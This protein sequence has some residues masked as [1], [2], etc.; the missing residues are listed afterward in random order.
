MIAAGR[1]R[2]GSVNRIAATPINPD[3]A[4]RG[5]RGAITVVFALNGLLF[6]S[7]ASRIPAVRDHA[8]ASN[9]ELG[10]ALGCLALGAIVAM[11]PAGAACGRIGSRRVTRLSL[12]G[13]A[14]AVA[15]VGHAPSVP[16]LCL[17]TFVLGA[18]NGA[19]DVS[20]NAHGVAVERRYG[21]P[22]LAGL[23]AAFSAG[24]LVGA[25]L[26]ALA[27]GAGLGVR[28]HLT[29][30]AAL[31]LAAGGVLS[32]RLLPGPVDVQADE[33]PPLFA[34]PP[35]RLW[36]LGALAF[37]CLLIEG[38]SADWSAVYL[39][40]DLEASAGVAALGFTAFS[41]TMVLGRLAGDRLVARFGAVRVVR[42]GGLVAAVGFG[43]ALL[44][45]TP[46]A[47]IAGLACLGAGMAGVVPVVFR[48]S[49]QMGD[50][51]PGAALAAVSSTGY[52]GFLA[53]PTV[54]GGLSEVTGLPWALALLVV[55]AAVVA[56]LGRTVGARAD[57]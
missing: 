18:G 36:A 15:V 16:I 26:G 53:G 23:H 2:A 48:A 52:L 1:R 27:A 57:G 8:G 6:G 9:G 33:R 45:A 49:G 31:A 39:H 28:P 32:R 29:L 12:V 21:R 41:V 42:G 13:A 37:A 3:A 22:I 35:R 44:A 50:P 19:L 55:L 46:V 25:G 47:A 51:S 40:D 7:W 20:M 56:G 4:T 24:G 14:G 17:F 30:A 5:A 34:L 54:I 38:A 43:V 10:I 11:P